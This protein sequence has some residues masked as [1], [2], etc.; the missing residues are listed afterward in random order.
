MIVDPS[1]L[2]EKPGHQMTLEELL[3]NKDAIVKKEE[4]LGKEEKER[5]IIKK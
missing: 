3:E 1:E 5:R 2:E 4:L